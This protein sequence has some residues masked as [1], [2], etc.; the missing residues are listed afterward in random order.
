MV[1]LIDL[2]SPGPPGFTLIEL[3]V[4]IAIIGLLSSIVLASLSTARSKGGD[5]AIK[6]DLNGV[7]VQAELANNNGCYV[8]S[9]GFC[10]ASAS[11]PATAPCVSGSASYLCS[12]PTIVR[13]MQ[14]ALAVGNTL[15]SFQQNAPATAYAVAVQLVTDKALAWCVDS[16]GQSK[17]EGSAGAAA[18]TQTALN[19]FT[20]SSACL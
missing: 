15:Q 5:A 12:D 18:L 6:S 14:G 1:A 17:P 13:I 16:S 11:T 8:G 7:Q 10:S 3:L 4:V 20:A 19:A 9:G 2:R